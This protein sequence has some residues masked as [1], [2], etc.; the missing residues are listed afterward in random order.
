[1]VG[2]TDYIHSMC[3]AHLD[4]KPEQF[5]VEDDFLTIVLAD[6]AHSVQ[7]Q[8]NDKLTDKLQIGT[9][10]Y[11]APETFAPINPND[12][13]YDPTLA[14]VFSLACILLKL[15]TGVHPFLCTNYQCGDGQ[16]CICSY[17]NF[18]E[19]FDMFFGDCLMRLKK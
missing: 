16:R 6:F 19:N 2:C 9:A 3:V 10:Y 11:R 1:M 12:H 17:E 14:D 4:L 13:R 15:L 5:L 8:E 7:F 18:D